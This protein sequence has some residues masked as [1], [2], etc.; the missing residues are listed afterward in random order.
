MSYRCRRLASVCFTPS[1][2]RH[3]P[4][5]STQPC[6]A[7]DR[8]SQQ[9][10]NNCSQHWNP[11]SL[12]CW[13]SC[14]A[15]TQM[16]PQL[17]QWLTLWRERRDDQSLPPCGRVDYCRSTLHVGQLSLTS[18]Q[19]RQRTRIA[20]IRARSLARSRLQRSPVPDQPL[21]IFLSGVQTLRRSNGMR[22]WQQL[23]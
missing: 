9:L 3:R 6:L 17:P 11:L 2:T 7:L 19:Y 15:S 22:H 8:A 4:L 21:V 12:L 18:Q 13:H 16:V 1:Q 10:C 14:N 5:P 20:T 23:R